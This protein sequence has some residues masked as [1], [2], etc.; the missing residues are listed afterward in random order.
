MPQL[1]LTGEIVLDILFKNKLV[2][3][4]LPGGSMLNTAVSLARAGNAPQFCGVTGQDEAGRY[5]KDFLESQGVKTALIRQIPGQLTPVT[6]GWLDDHNNAAYTF[7]KPPLP[8]P[9]VQPAIPALRSNDLL[10]AGSFFAVDPLRQPLM[11]TLRR[12]LADCRCLFYYDLNFRKNHLD[13]LGEVMPHLR[14][15]LQAAGIIKGSEEDFRLVFGHDSPEAIR[16]L[17]PGGTEKVLVVTAG[18][19]QVDFLYRDIR[20]TLPVE[21]IRPLSTVGAGDGFNAGFIHALRG[22]YKGREC[23]ETWDR[24]QWEGC[25]RSGMAFAKAVCASEE[26]YI[27]SG[28]LAEQ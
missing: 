24:S 18:D 7:H 15:N 11:E 9:A 23:I 25:I 13:R 26:N 14:A 2:I 28:F 3:K 17:I 21:K 4:A 10:A 20:L 8:S 5:I 16:V 6:L 12:Q 1:V 19:R 27:P 22:M